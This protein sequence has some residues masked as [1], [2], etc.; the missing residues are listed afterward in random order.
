MDGTVLI[1]KL[2]WF[3]TSFFDE[4]WTLIEKLGWI[5]F[6]QFL[7]SFEWCFNFFPDATRTFKISRNLSRNSRFLRLFWADFNAVCVL[8]VGPPQILSNTLKLSKLS[9]LGNL[10]FSE[11]GSPAPGSRSSFLKDFN[12]VLAHFGRRTQSLIETL[13]LAKPFI[14]NPKP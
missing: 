2:F 3:F 9:K 14:V 13:R 4:I 7:G 6:R 11:L 8:F 1:Q 5:C 10:N 12:G